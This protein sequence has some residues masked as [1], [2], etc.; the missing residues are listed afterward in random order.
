MILED[1]IRLLS[2]LG[3][4]MLS[5]DPSWQKAKKKAS[6][7]NGWFIPEFIDLATNNIAKKFLT[8]D[9][10]STRTNHRSASTYR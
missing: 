2:R 10:L 6:L 3:A 4:F 7:Q 5:D 1:R 8:A 9:Q